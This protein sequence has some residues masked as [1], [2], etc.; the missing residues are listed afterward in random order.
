MTAALTS[1]MQPRWADQPAHQCESINGVSPAKGLKA[2]AKAACCNVHTWGDV[3]SIKH[4][5]FES[6]YAELKR[7]SG[8]SD[9]CLNEGRSLSV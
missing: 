9:L 1:G 5:M 3:P 6:I 4:S 2:E 8:R 7:G